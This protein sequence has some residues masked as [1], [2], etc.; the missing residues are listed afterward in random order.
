MLFKKKMILEK[1]INNCFLQVQ[2]IA[3]IMMMFFK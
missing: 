1:K 3:T 2:M